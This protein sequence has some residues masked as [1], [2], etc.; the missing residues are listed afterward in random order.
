MRVGGETDFIAL[1][2]ITER[3]TVMDARVATR[4]MV[5]ARFGLRN[6]PTFVGTASPGQSRALRTCPTPPRNARSEERAHSSAHV[7]GAAV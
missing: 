5:T 4:S 6:D 3:S 7:T 2:R 1:T